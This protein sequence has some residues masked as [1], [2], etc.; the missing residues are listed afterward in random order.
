MTAMQ[1]HQETPPSVRHPIQAT[2][3]EIQQLR[4]E[5]R[6]RVHLA[7]MDAKAL[8]DE[9]EPRLLALEDEAKEAKASAAVALRQT[10]NELLA[11]YKKLRAK[12]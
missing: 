8:W 4:D 3:A 9:L 6:V 5:M 7:G 1:T 2:L 10:A 12:L 11:A